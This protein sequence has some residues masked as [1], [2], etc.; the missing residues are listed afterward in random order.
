MKYK[1]IKRLEQKSYQ[2]NLHNF[3]F[4][5]PQINFTWSCTPKQPNLNTKLHLPQC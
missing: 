4:A 3:L 5:S 2:Q 1:I